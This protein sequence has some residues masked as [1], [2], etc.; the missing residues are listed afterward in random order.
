MN[1]EYVIVCRGWADG[2]PD[3]DNLE[4]AFLREYDPEFAGGLGV[5]KWTRDL[6]EAL[7]FT[8][9]TEIFRLWKLSP[10]SRP[11]R[12]DGRPNRPLTAF[13]IEIQPCQK[14]S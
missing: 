8:D 2:R 5:A 7:K 3:P 1:I 6:D 11:T 14:R 12:E 4:G 9:V 10:K 13:T